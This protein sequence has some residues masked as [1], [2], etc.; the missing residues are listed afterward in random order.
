MALPSYYCV[1]DA[2]VTVKN[3]P[4]GLSLKQEQLTMM[5]TFALF[6]PGEMGTALGAALTSRG[7]RVLWASQGRSIQ[8]T[9]R[10]K[11]ANLEDAC[12]IGQAVKAAQFVVSVCPPHAALALANA[13]TAD[14]FGGT[15]VDANAISPDTARKIST[16]IETAGGTFVDGGIIG[17][18]PSG[19]TQPTFYLSG[20]QAATVADLFDG[21]NIRAEVIEGGAG[22]ASALKMCYAAYTKGTA[23]LLAAVRALAEYEGVERPLLESWRRTLPDLPRQ[24]E[25]AAR[26]ASKAW[27]WSGEMEEIA[28]SFEAA[29]LPEGFHQA[30][31]EVYRR[32]ESFKN[33]ATPPSMAEVIQAMQRRTETGSPPPSKKGIQ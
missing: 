33:C 5:K 12:T 19:L 30:A 9:A 27:R 26:A 24:S 10:A 25:H 13:A 22:A 14:G 31:A 29:G 2:G 17:L 23:A 7:S 16:V 11:A 1:A 28:A 8:T 21:T 32:L 18:P 6:H 4:Y 15:Y 20:S 3:A